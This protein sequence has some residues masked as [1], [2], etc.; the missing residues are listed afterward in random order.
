MNLPPAP[1]KSTQIDM[2]HG[3]TRQDEYAWL[4]DD[5]WQEVMHNPAVLD[6]KIR[7]HLEAENAYCDAMLAPQADLRETL[8]AEM[9][10]RIQEDESALGKNYGDFSWGQRYE[11]GAQHPLICRGARNADMADAEIILNL[12]HYAQD[13]A[14]FKS[15]FFAPNPDAQKL[16]WGFDDKGSEYFTLAIY[17]ITTAQD[18]PDRIDKSDGT[19]AWDATGDFLFYVALDDHHRPF[20]IMRHRLG[21]KQAE[22]ICVYEEQDAGFFINLHKTRSGR[23]IIISAHD[24]ET[25]ENWLI[26]AHAPDTPPL[27]IAPR[28]HAIE[29]YVDDDAAQNRLLILTNSQADDFQ[30]VTVACDEMHAPWQSLIPHQSGRLILDIYTTRHHI[31]WLVRENAVPHIYI[32]DKHSQHIE[33][34]DFAEPAYHLSLDTGLEYDTD[35]L[36]FSYSSMTTPEHIYDY[37]MHTHERTLRKSQHIPSGHVPDNYV[38][39]R[40]YARS[41]DGARVPL[42]LLYHK[43]TPLDGSAPALLYGYGAYGITIPAGF[44][45]TRLSLVDRGFIYCIAHIRGGKACG[46]K[47]FRD[48][49]GA[50]KTNTFEDFLAAARELIAQNLT[51]EKH[52]TIHGGSA[53]GLL[54]GAA[55]NMAPDLFCGAIAEVPFV[56]VLTTMLDDGLPLTPPEWPEWGNPIIDKTA[57]ETIAAYSPYDNISKTAY[58]H[59]LATAGL[60]DPR[61]TYWEPAKWIARLRDTRIDDGL[62]LLYTH[63]QAGHGGKS[64]R[65]HQ[66]DEIAMIYAFI[67]MIHKIGEA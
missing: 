56:D 52:I 62:S 67:L 1:T 59:I 16:A 42:S 49:R 3:K 39:K 8:Y 17:D 43:D 66:L 54:V 2:H 13:K 25:T 47:W 37:D 14:Y 55:V 60:T 28:R 32:M 18:L 41:H 26:D 31:A 21:T 63:M 58:P 29:Y 46:D 12:N 20:R 5:N 64:G 35:I 15:P 61:V 6:R 44:S 30:I 48:G 7:A 51:R 50:K 45:T 34:I 53:G 23:Y 4:R 22:D 24:H 65:F 27:C 38:T 33:K 9:R 19:C 40:L 57:Y 11:A 36:R 10:A